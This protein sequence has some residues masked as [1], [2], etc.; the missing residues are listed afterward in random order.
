MT[1]ADKPAMLEIC[2]RIWEGTDYLPA[3][4]DQWVA[5]TDGEFAAAVLDGKLAGC[6]KLTYLTASDAW[7]EGLR[8]DPRVRET[9]LGEAVARYFL[10]RLAARP[11]LASVRFSTYIGNKKSIAANEKVGFRRRTALSVKA[12]EGTREELPAVLSATSGPNLR[13]QVITDPASV[14]AFLRRTGY[15]QPL[16]G[17][18]VEG[19]RAWPWSEEL[20]VDRYVKTGFCRGVAGPDGLRALSIVAVAGTPSRTM[21]RL[22]CLDALDEEGADVMMGDVMAETRRAIERAAAARWEI[23]WMIPRVPRLMAWAARGG[24]RSWEQEDDFLV[25]EFP[26]DLLRRLAPEPPGAGT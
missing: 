16:E 24:L 26:L 4:F 3:V 23:E 8:K 21:I 18:V 11:R 5:D 7:L 19:W 12:R 13:A 1:M 22:V 15:F 6:G 17:L 2:S 10:G 9:G 25:Y 20:L 14:L